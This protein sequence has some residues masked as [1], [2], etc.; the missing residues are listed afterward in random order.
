MQVD[1]QHFMVYE[2]AGERLGYLL[3]REPELRP[4]LL[5]QAADAIAELLASGILNCDLKPGHFYAQLVQA[6]IYRFACPNCL[7]RDHR[8]CKHYSLR[9]A[10]DILAR[11]LCIAHA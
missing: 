1:S 7:L 9:F 10:T 2:D 6:G 3:Q 8:P 4:A 5:L 11:R